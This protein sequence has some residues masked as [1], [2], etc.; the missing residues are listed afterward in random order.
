MDA[1]LHL[2]DIFD[3]VEVVNPTALTPL[4]F[5]G[6]HAGNKVPST[7]I[8]RMGPMGLS[9]E[10][11][12]QHIGWDIGAAAV[13]RGLARRLNATAVLGVYTRLLIDPNRAL[14]DW[15]SIPITS[16]GIVIP[17]NA[18]L[19]FDEMHARAE[20]FFWPYHQAVDHHL[21]RLKHAGR[22]PLLVSMHSFTPMLMSN[23]QP[24]P[25]H[26][27][28]MAS[29]DRRLMD[30]LIAGLRGRGDL[31]VGDNEP[32]SGVDLGYCL[33]L[34]GLAQGLPHAQ[35]EVR[36]DQIDS[37]AGQERWVDLLADILRPIL[38]DEKFQQ[39]AH[40]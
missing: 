30:A 20:Q 26:V 40:Y 1:Q 12:A 32:Y 25:W 18:N 38:A 4:L 19:S 36:Q 33:K 27:G 21:A 31:V 37:I 10:T 39:V 35:I 6:D 29:R 16:D 5:I 13:A 28:I 7:M 22:V 34:H 3:A 14:G 23:G 2:D 24:R 15:G 17:A 11:L 9:S 8:D